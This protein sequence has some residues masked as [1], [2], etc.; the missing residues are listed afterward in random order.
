[1][2]LAPDSAL[3]A[4]RPG[5]A[6]WREAEFLRLLDFGRAARDPRGGF[7]WLSDE[8]TIEPEGPRP[9]FVTCRMTHCYA[10]GALRG[11]DGAAELAA[12]GM[13]ALETVFRD[14]AH[15][16]WVEDPADPG[17]DKTAYGHAFVALAASSAWV[18]GL[19]RSAVF[20][21]ILDVIERHFWNGGSLQES[22]SA[23]WTRA[24]PYRGAN[25]TM[26]MTEAYLAVSDALAAG[27]EHAG[28]EDADAAAQWRARALQMTE[29]IIHGFAA[30]NGWRIPEHF[31]V[32]WRPRLDYNRDD[33]AHPFR[34]YGATVGHALE[35][36]RLCLHQYAGGGPQWLRDDAVA[37]IDRAVTDG[38]AVDGAVGFLYTTDW[39]G[40]PVVGDRM[41]WVLAE[42]VGAA[43]VF[44][45]ALGDERWHDA[46]E[47]WWRY[48]ETY[49]VDREHGSWRHQLD[50][51]NRPTSTV[52]AG[53]PDLYHA[54]QACLPPD[55][56]PDAS[57]ARS[58]RQDRH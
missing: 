31:D 18:A 15:G 44:Q 12:H 25:S 52:W 27:D 42:A 17:A 41:H 49:L 20:D 1:M 11:V 5:S 35:W 30:D 26:H 13:S 2:T 38:W 6:A 24:E 46:A 33:P 43:A 40:A 39:D 54:I 53:K 23:D 14:V 32:D 4:A 56:A 3:S 22:F 37:L 55:L 48:A 9:L 57:I 45:R 36:A 16:G 50:A 29:R 47:Q 34:P 8:G 19:G 28:D 51:S 7:G 21:D 58:L 10:L